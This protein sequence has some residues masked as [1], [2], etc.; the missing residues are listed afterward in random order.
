MFAHDAVRW[1]WFPASPGGGGGPERCCFWGATSFGG[2]TRDPSPR[3]A[4]R[5][6]FDISRVTYDLMHTRLLGEE[7]EELNEA[8]SAPGPP[9]PLRFGN[10]IWAL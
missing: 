10:T 1:N 8:F 5:K 9:A 7:L 6:D 3:H 2:V 4:S